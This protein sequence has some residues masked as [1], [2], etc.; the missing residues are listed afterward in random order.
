MRSAFVIT[1]LFLCST[2]CFG[3]GKS[4][5]VALSHCNY[6][7]ARPS[8]VGDSESVINIVVDIIA[9]DKNFGEIDEAA[10]KD[11]SGS[12]IIVSSDGYIVTNCHVIDSSE[13][14]DV[15]LYDGEK[16]AAKVVGKDVRSDIALL[17]IDKTQI[18]Y[19]A[20]FADSDTVNILEPVFVVGNP[21]GFGKTV[22]SGIISSKGRNLSSQIAELGAGGDLV[23]YLQ[24]DAAVNYGNSGGPLFT[25]DG[26]VVGMITV[27]VS[28]GLHSTGINFAIPANTVKSIV[29]QLK[30]NGKIERSWTG[31]T[32]KLLSRDVSIAL[33]LG[34]NRSGCSVTKVSKNSPAESAG[35]KVGDIMLSINGQEITERTNIESTLCS[36]PI[37]ATIPVKILKDDKEI[38]C[39]IKVVADEGKSDQ[40]SDQDSAAKDIA[41]EKLEGINIEIANLTLE[42][43]QRFNIP[44]NINGVLIAKVENESSS[45]SPGNVILKINST[46]VSNT[47][48]LKAKMREVTEERRPEVAFYIYDPSKDMQKFYVPFKLEYSSAKSA[49]N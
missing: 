22:T 29:N 5:P 41:S 8:F 3:F 48:D 15:V 1:I 30:E 44:D 4:S 28:D 13:R 9:V 35:L 43:R 21:F 40:T 17:R 39:Y 26:K 32:A 7:Y 24:T 36:L 16:Y 45:M 20:K 18:P 2:V 14:I 38:V 10:K 6:R 27:F 49:A 23:S 37:G 34:N 47:E 25:Y 19:V 33:G 11:S 31:I 42:Y 12:G 46:D